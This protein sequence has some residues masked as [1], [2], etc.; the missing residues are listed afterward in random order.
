MSSAESSGS[1]SVGLEFE[2]LAEPGRGTGVDEEGAFFGAE[3]FPVSAAEGGQ[4]VDWDE[5]LVALPPETQ[6]GDVRT[7]TGTEVDM[8]WTGSTDL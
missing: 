8:K 3:V 7:E 2:D 1:S 6:R 4:T 5:A